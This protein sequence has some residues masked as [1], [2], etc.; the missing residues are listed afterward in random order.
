MKKAVNAL[1]PTLDLFSFDYAHV[2]LPVEPKDITPGM[3]VVLQDKEYNVLQVNGE[4]ILQVANV[5]NP[6]NENI[7]LGVLPFTPYNVQKSPFPPPFTQQSQDYEKLVALCFTVEKADPSVI[8]DPDHSLV[9]M[10]L[11]KVTTVEPIE[12]NSIYRPT[13]DDIDILTDGALNRLGIQVLYRSDV[14]MTGDL[15]P[16]YQVVIQV[17]STPFMVDYL[18]LL[19]K[20]NFLYFDIRK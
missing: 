14:I 15:D 8:T 4:K 20:D 2:V 5:S 12:L 18:K 13:I 3:I 19:S 11:Y 6:D 7:S 17:L 9:P 10:E 1:T 16:I